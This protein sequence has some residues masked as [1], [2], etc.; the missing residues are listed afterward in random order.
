MNR[1]EKETV[2]AVPA[3]EYFVSCFKEKR[4]FAVFSLSFFSFFLLSRRSIFLP[5]HNTGEKLLGL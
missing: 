3:A 2:P 4:S 1:K 5:G